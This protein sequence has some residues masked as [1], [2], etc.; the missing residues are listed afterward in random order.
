MSEQRKTDRRKRRWCFVDLITDPY[1][2]KMKET[3]LWSNLGKLS[4]LLWFSWKCYND[5]DTIELWFVV[6][7]V[8][9]AHAAFS[10]VVSLKF[11]GPAEKPE[12][13]RKAK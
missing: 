9:T 6:M 7:L 11:G 2:G 5:D 13:E 8:L 3:L 10:Q 12:L 4:A 1:S